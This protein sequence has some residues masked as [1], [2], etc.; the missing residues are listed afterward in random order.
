[1]NNSFKLVVLAASFGFLV[2]CHKKTD[3]MPSHPSENGGETK[4]PVDTSMNSDPNKG[5]MVDLDD[6]NAAPCLKSRTVNFDL[7]QTSVKSEF[8]DII[9]CHAKYL[10]FHPTARL[11]LEGNA[12]ERGSR[13]YNRGLGERRG[14]AVNDML[15]AQGGKSEQIS[16]ISYGEERPTCNDSNEECWAQNRRVD[17]VYTAK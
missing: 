3:V 12:D 9:A 10:G 8:Q 11:N 15:Q 1:M 14:N 2:A 4:P 16:V 5:Y 6:P 7:D 13:E 17:L